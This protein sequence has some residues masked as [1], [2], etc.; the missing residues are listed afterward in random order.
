MSVYLFS[1]G[2]TLHVEYAAES[3]TLENGGSDELIDVLLSTDSLEPVD[4]IHIVYPH[5]IPLHDP[6]DE[7]QPT[8]SDLTA[9]WLEPNSAFNLFYTQGPHRLT[10]EYSEP[11]STWVTV[12]MV[13]PS[14]ITRHLEYKGLIQ[15]SLSLVPYELTER[16]RLDDVEWRIL[17]A[18]RWSIFSVK[19]GRPLQHKEPRWLRL[20]GQTGTQALNSMGRVERTLRLWTGAHQDNF[21][22]AGPLD[23]RH[24]L[25]THLQAAP[26]F[27]PSRESEGF[28]LDR[29]HSLQEKVLSRGLQAPETTTAINDWRIN[30]FPGSYRECDQPSWW[31]DLEPS[32]SLSNYI[33]ISDG[34]S[35]CF[36]WKAGHA[37]IQHPS[38]GGSFG[39]WIRT[40]NR[41]LIL[42]LLPWIALIISL[43]ALFV[44]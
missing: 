27:N 15:G 8:F 44:V 18:L 17:S 14:D 25:I 22:F 38:H 26:L 34:F 4:R 33:P 7:N 32:G 20:R 42:N 39:A 23:V 11:G 3:I 31:G 1:P 19:L 36:Q 13:D 40:H 37:N 2:S 41:P 6:P 30:I 24:R 21:E 43:L 29:L 28:L 10:L 12:A 5:P 16:D 35:R 9:T